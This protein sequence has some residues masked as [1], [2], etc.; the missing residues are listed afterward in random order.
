MQTALE[1]VFIDQNGYRGQTW[2]E[3]EG[4]CPILPPI[5]KT[6]VARPRLY[7]YLFGRGWAGGELLALGLVWL[8][9]LARPAVLEIKPSMTNP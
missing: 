6:P 1:P 5:L 3:V 8:G 2:A 4:P 9:S 7:S